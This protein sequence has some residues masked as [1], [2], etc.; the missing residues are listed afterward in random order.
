MTGDRG[1]GAEGG[2][3]KRIFSPLLR[4][5]RRDC[6]IP[7]LEAPE[8]AYEWEL[9]V[10]A[11]AEKKKG[12]LHR[13]LVRLLRPEILAAKE[14]GKKKEVLQSSVSHILRQYFFAKE[15]KKE[16]PPDWEVESRE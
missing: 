16:T 10:R 1:R 12:N 9:G 7:F 15:E 13:T 4:P 6:K 2:E 14:E 8:V 11:T 3:M 5:L